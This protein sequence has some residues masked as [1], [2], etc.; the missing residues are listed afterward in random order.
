MTWRARLFVA[1]VLLAGCR[2]EGVKPEAK[3]P[4]DIIL[5]TI[6]TWRADAAGFAGNTRVQT[7]F[8]D[9]L[10]SRGTLF[11]NAHAHSVVTLPSHTNILTGLLPFEHGVRDNAGFVLDARHPTIA[12]LLQQHGYATA[13]FVAAF[14]LDA[15]FG[16]NRGFDVYDDN[17]GKGASNLEFVVPERDAA[18]TLS[19]AAKWWAA[20]AGR[21]RFMWVHLYDPHAPYRPPAP[22]DSGYRD[23]PYL[24]EVAGV[25]ARLRE[26]LGPL[27]GGDTLIVVTADHGEALGDHG[28]LTHGLF[29]YE[30]TLKVPLIVAGGGAPAARDSRRARHIDIAPTILAAASIAQ[31]QSMKGQSLLEPGDGGD[32]YFEALSAT[33]NRGWAPL[34]GIIHDD[35]KYIELPLA[36][37]YDLSDDPREQKNLRESDRRAADERKRMLAGLAAAASPRNVAAEDVARLRSLGYIGGN[38]AQKAE[39]T[40]ADDP[41]SLIDIDSRMHRVIAAY[42]EG[43]VA[44]AVKGARELVAAR[45][46]MSAGRELFAFVLQESDDVA[47]AIAQLRQVV[48]APG[49]SEDS[50]VQLALLLSETGR[51]SEAVALLAPLAGGR[52]PDA[53][54]A[55]GVALADEGQ[56]EEGVKQFERVLAIDSNNAPALQNRGIVSLRGNDVRGAE[57]FLQRALELNPRLP[58][59]L[60]ALGVV[61]ARSDD[62]TGAVDAW[63]RAVAID[64]RQY[65]ALFNIAQVEAR[66]GNRDRAREALTQFIRTAPPSRYRKELAAARAELARGR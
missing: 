14:P 29:A 66:A 54:N 41:K 38:A 24:G 57:K 47:G 46:G 5:I 42:S 37:L 33:L 16:L 35:Q 59:A 55:Y 40:A 36:E 52:N 43:K 49:S 34:I 53:L 45:P 31:P 23:N 17:Y 30:S 58:L 62:L 1:C 28:E 18:R 56:P 2:S 65:D 4:R 27:I 61:R 12:T 64:P 8:L 44:E 19:A 63:R 48:R 6:D 26:H 15:R 25:D 60:N 9:G 13:A 22:Y 3:H 21:K 51:S 10:A 20:S 32:T 39:Y 50:R 7:P 11:M